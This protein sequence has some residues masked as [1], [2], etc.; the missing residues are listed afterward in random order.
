MRYEAIPAPVHRASSPAPEISR[1]ERTVTTRRC[2][3]GSVRP[4]IITA[5]MR[6]R[7]YILTH[8]V[9][10]FAGTLAVLY[11]VMLIVQWVRLGR[12]LSIRD[13]DVS[14]SPWS[15]CRRS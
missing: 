14:S 10:V 4:V 11:A 15:P 13:V 2:G 3:Q 6:I 1:Q 5:H 12:A 8:L 7:G 9:Q